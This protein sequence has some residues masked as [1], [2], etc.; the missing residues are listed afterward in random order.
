[1]ND[2]H[3]N[4]Y[5]NCPDC[6]YGYPLRLFCDYCGV[7]GPYAVDP[8]KLLQSILSDINQGLYDVLKGAQPSTHYSTGYH[9]AIMFAVAMISGRLLK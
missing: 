9:D 7:V 2:T 5:L 8:D 4:V 3:A 1:M 6:T